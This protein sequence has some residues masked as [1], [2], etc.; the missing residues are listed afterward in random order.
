MAKRT[1]KRDPVKHAEYNRRY[2]ENPEALE[3]K[4]ARDRARRKNLSED[5]REKRLEYKRVSRRVAKARSVAAEIQHRI[6]EEIPVQPHGFQ[7]VRFCVVCGAEYTAKTPRAKTCGVICRKKRHLIMKDL[8]RK[9][10][11]KR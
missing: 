8:R 11:G 6:V 5:E 2:L 10:T 9:R 1:R 7:E 3:R 4:R